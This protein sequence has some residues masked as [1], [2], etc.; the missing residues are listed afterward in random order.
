MGRP[1]DGAASGRRETE[2]EG[3]VM[4]EET[5]AMGEET[6][7][8][9][10]FEVLSTLGAGEMASPAAIYGA[11]LALVTMANEEWPDIEGGAES[12]ADGIVASRELVA[13]LKAAR[14]GVQ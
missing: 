13:A 4:E 1:G 11:C 5:E 8:K 6:G 9:A 12:V 10:V 7:A 14:A 2:K 3:E